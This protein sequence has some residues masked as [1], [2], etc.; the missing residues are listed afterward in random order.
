MRFD[1]VPKRRVLVETGQEFPET[2]YY[3]DH[4][5]GGGECCFVTR[6]AKYGMLFK[7][8][9]RAPNLGS[10]S[11]TDGVWMPS[12]RPGPEMSLIGSRPGACPPETPLFRSGRPG[13]VQFNHVPK[14]KAV[15]ETGHVFPET[16]YYSYVGHR[17]GDD[18]GCFVSVYAERGMLFKKGMRAPNLISCSHTVSWRLTAVY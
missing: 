18:E 13:T 3:V 14:R 15:V 4:R 12:T 16:G 6:H 8:G 17:D 11:H 5:D 2:V 7:R 9:M 1:H 10:C